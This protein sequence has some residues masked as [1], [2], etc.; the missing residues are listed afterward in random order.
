[1]KQELHLLCMVALTGLLCLLKTTELQAQTGLGLRLGQPE[2]LSLTL[3]GRLTMEGAAFLPEN[4]SNYSWTSKPGVTEPLQMAPGMMISQA[5]LGLVLEYKKWSGRIDANFSGNKVSLTDTYIRYAYSAQGNI[6]L[7]H[8]FDPI[9]IGLNTPSRHN[10]LAMAAPVTFLTPAV[11]HMGITLTQWGEKYWISGGLYAGSISSTLAEAD[12]ASEGYGV[13]ARLA[14]LPIS[15]ESQLLLL[16]AG[17]STRT[18]ERTQDRTGSMLFSADASTAVDR[19]KFVQTS[20]PYVQRYET[21][22]LGAAYRN[23]KFF[24]LG[25]FLLN[26]VGHAPIAG[27]VP[28]STI[29]RGLFVSPE[30]YQTYLGGYLTTSYMLRGEQRVYNRSSAT[31]RNTADEIEP[32][33]NLELMARVSYLDADEGGRMLEGLAALNWY[34]NKYF[35]LGLNYSYSAMNRYA[36]AGGRLTSSVLGGS[37]FRLHT[38]QLRAQLV[39]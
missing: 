5:R 38:L 25:E 7:G 37:T 1:M 36:T 21:F 29:K 33:G 31:F 19:H 30:A 35:L 15:T 10:S 24:A 3:D 11:R 39:F 8:L 32:G 13:S 6:S 2:E 20:V 23:P 27:A 9:S 34:P 28:G 16:S 22:T 12:Y 18:P 4:K 26:N 14:F 17:A